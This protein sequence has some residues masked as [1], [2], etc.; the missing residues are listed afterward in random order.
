M[1]QSSP[2]PDWYIGTISGD[3]PAQNQS[4]PGVFR[5]LLFVLRVVSCPGTSN[6]AQ[7]CRVNRRAS[8]GALRTK[9]QRSPGWPFAF[10]ARP[11]CVPGEVE[12]QKTAHGVAHERRSRAECLARENK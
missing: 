10:R 5:A 2:V 11:F 12:S 9:W 8:T 4:P 7:I 1:N 6:F 3:T